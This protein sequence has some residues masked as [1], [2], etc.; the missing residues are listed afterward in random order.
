[1][2]EME[3]SAWFLEAHALSLIGGLDLLSSNSQV[4]LN[5]IQAFFYIKG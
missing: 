5:G 2:S 4:N 3:L 1:M